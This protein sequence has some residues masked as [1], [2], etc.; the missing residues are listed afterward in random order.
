[1]FYTKT[2]WLRL[3]DIEISSLNV[4]CLLLE[5]IGLSY[6]SRCHKQNYQFQNF[7]RKSY[8]FKSCSREA[9]NHQLTTM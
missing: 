3:Q 1:M 9:T 2:G 5:G 6:S 4:I 7:E 8:I